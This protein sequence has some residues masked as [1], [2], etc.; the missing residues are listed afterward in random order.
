[1]D[2]I[3][4]LL[5][6]LDRLHH[7]QAELRSYE[8]R[9]AECGEND[10]ASDTWK[11]AAIVAASAEADFQ[12][13]LIRN[14]STISR[15]LRE[16]AEGCAPKEEPKSYW[17]WWAGAN[18][19]WCTIGPC[20][21]RDQVIAEA[22]DEVLGEFQDGDTWKLGFHICEANKPPLRLAD[23][24]GADDLLGQA[25]DAICDSDRVSCEYDEGPWF[26]ASAEQEADLER[27]VKAACDAW[28][29][30]HGLVFTCTSFSS[31]RNHEH[32]V[33]PH[34]LPDDPPPPATET[35]KTEEP[36]HDD[37]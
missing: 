12:A 13:V 7:R 29:A 21:S 19:E 3:A 2:E 31:S 37:R 9:L 24:I 18:E 16:A 17:G 33:V 8:R 4:H 27:R 11:M 30:A 22:T 26:H 32:V 15:V 25:E 36:R 1:M 20:S 6:E 23:W 34:P 28:Q 5:S 14:Y 35:T 10:P